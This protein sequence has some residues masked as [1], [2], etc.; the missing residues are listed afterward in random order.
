MAALDRGSV[1]LVKLDPVAGHEQAGTR[2]CVVVSPPEVNDAMRFPLI[3]VVP[4]TRTPGGGIL[5]P[6]IPRKGAGLTADSYAL[7]DQVRSIDK[8]RVARVFGRVADE[9]MAAV[10]DGLRAFLGL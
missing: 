7:T 10:D 1:V 4:L 5:Y 9:Q 2:P 6:R 3:A 8:V